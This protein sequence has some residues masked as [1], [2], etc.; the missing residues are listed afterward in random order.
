MTDIALEL[1]SVGE[2]LTGK[3]LVIPGYQRRYSWLDA[4]R[5]TLIQD[6]YQHQISDQKI[7]DRYFCGS[8]ILEILDEKKYGVADGQQ[9]IT[10]MII[11][12]KAL[13]T[14][15]EVAESD[16]ADIITAILYRAKNG[17]LTF[18]DSKQ[19][20]EFKRCLSLDD[21]SNVK[22]N[23]DIAYKQ[24]L[25]KLQQFHEGQLFAF[26]SH[27]IHFTTFA[28][29]IAPM[30]S[31]LLLFERAN[32]RGLALSLT[33]RCKSIVLNK[34][35]D[36]VAVSRSWEQFLTYCQATDRSSDHHLLSY[37]WL[38]SSDGE[39][40]TAKS[41]IEAFQG[42]IK[43]SSDELVFDL[44]N[45]AEYA[46]NLELCLIPYV[47]LTCRNF[48]YLNC[49]RK[50]HQVRAVMAAARK[51]PES[52]Q[53]QFLAE[54]EKTAMVIALTSPLPGTVTAMLKE[55]LISI[56]DTKQYSDTASI[57]RKYRSSLAYSMDDCIRH[58]IVVS[59]MNN[60]RALL[61]YLEAYL[62]QNN[63]STVLAAEDMGGTIEHI[64]PQ[65]KRDYNPAVDLTGN[66]TLLDQTIN[67]HIGDADFKYKTDAY[68]HQK[69]LLT[70][71]LVRDF[72]VASRNEKLRP[73]VYK[74]GETWDSRDI[75]ARG[76]M[77]SKL[78]SKVFDYD[79]ESAADRSD[80]YHSK[81]DIPQ[82]DNLRSVYNTLLSVLAG[83]STTLEIYEFHKAMLDKDIDTRLTRY[84][85][86]ALELLDLV[87]R[88]K[89]E[90]GDIITLS[91]NGEKAAQLEYVDFVKE[92]V[93]T[94]PVLISLS[95]MT[96]DECIAFITAHS[97]VEA[98]TLVRRYG[99]L[100]A[101]FK[102][103]GFDAKSE[104]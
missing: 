76:K 25:G 93:A 15:R 40:V 75:I 48:R 102:E 92:Y 84:T 51:M 61:Y 66:L 82:A 18:V 5:A 28:V 27:I 59:S 63:G 52:I 95:K 8:I 100:R 30:Y 62:Q 3:N 9:R 86:N 57:L 36:E 2:L 80:P 56:Q 58:N 91:S 71:S 11:L 22:S 42:L 41:A 26:A 96:R 19:D 4:Q 70:Q 68:Q 23:F 60:V 97:T 98:S 73:E 77:L 72:Q 47:K 44:E 74:A 64:L 104:N 87:N 101:W 81:I 34:A 50:Q 46:N 43:D 29:T 35:N 67:S 10:T 7:I 83:N 69:F 16:I 90:L 79:Y 55:V 14:F 20:K 24:M 1:V 33:D 88:D 6:I 32:N 49:L 13:L 37:L 21:I 38:S 39:R 85:I 89:S 17:L 45:H 103:C 99:C 94:N 54:L 31:G 78:A 53:R 12:L 65:S